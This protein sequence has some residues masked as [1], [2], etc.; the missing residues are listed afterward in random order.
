[1]NL[2]LVVWVG[3]LMSADGASAFAPS[4]SSISS[5]AVTLNPTGTSAPPARSTRPLSPQHPSTRMMGLRGGGDLQDLTEWGQDDVC[6]RHNLYRLVAD[7]DPQQVEP[8]VLER[9]PPLG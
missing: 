4:S 5:A 8:R 6:H 7:H 1:M 2:K 3:V 9:S